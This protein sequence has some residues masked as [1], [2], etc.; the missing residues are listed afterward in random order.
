M[1]HYMYV[2]MY[3]CMCMSSQ[4]KM[5]SEEA[6]TTNGKYAKSVQGWVIMVTGLHPEITEDHLLDAFAEY[7]PPP[8]AASDAAD[9]DAD[10]QP[11][12]PS[13]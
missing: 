5:S 13:L 4:T 9:M 12:P 8:A 2:C 6:T 10:N 1:I 3:V 11:P 7:A